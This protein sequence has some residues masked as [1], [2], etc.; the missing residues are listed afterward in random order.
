MHGY[1]YPLKLPSSK[2]HI[3][4]YDFELLS[5]RVYFSSS[6]TMSKFSRNAMCVPC[7]YIWDLPETRDNLA[8]TMQVQA[9]AGARPQKKFWRCSLVRFLNTFDL[10]SGLERK[11]LK[12]T[13]PSPVW[14]VCCNKRVGDRQCHR[15][16]ICFS[17]LIWQSGTILRRAGLSSRRVWLKS[18]WWR[19][20]RALS[21]QEGEGKV[22]GCLQLGVDQG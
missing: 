21:D 2:H 5:F 19:F 13:L 16:T 4:P 20:A 1:Q 14:Q 11:P 9:R 6:N 17:Y 15:L 8:G 10:W 22:E 7:L 3:Q 12:S 18:A